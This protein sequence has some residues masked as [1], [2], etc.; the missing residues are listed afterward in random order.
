MI[1]WAWLIVA[2]IAGELVGISAMALCAAADTKKEIKKE[3]P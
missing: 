2:F 1:H 3:D